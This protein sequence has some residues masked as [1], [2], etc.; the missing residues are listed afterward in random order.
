MK[1]ET[2]PVIFAENEFQYEEKPLEKAF[3]A[4]FTPH[5]TNTRK[6]HCKNFP[7]TIIQSK[8]SAETLMENEIDS[9]GGKR[10]GTPKRI[11]R[12]NYFIFFSDNQNTL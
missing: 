3:F 7:A 9:F 12:K 10:I 11:V 8:L 4:N 6:V 5:G 1:L 2:Q